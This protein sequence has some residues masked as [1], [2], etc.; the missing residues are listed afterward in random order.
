MLDPKQLAQ[1]KTQ[2]VDVCQRLDQRQFVA[3]HDGNVSIRLPNGHYL[4]TPTSFAKADI[5]E[6]DILLLDEKGAVIEGK[7]KVFSEMA[8]HRSIYRVRPDVTCIVHG[9]PVTASGYGLANREI[10]LPSLPEAI[11][12]LGRHILTTGFLSP[13]DPSVNQEGGAFDLEFS[14]ALAQSDA[15]VV[16]GNGVWAVGQNVL[17]AYLRLELVEHI[18]RQH[19]AAQ[20]LGGLKP[21]PGNL[22][23]ELLKKRPQPK[24]SES[25]AS[26]LPALAIRSH[27]DSLQTS[28][29]NHPSFE[30]LKDI[31]RDELQ[32]ILRQ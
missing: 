5:K 17:Q 9:H 10:G 24:L 7:H 19:K 1:L 6:G 23:E 11:V 32:T 14:R 21:L 3:N 18:A 31:V 20:E 28:Q 16:P 15:C 29:A 4:A 13:L 8:W 2:I 26:P 30:N 12:S 25:T 22:V 27:G